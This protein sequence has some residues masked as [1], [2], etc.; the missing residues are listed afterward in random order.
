MTGLDPD[1][2]R[3]IEIAIVVTDSQL[4]TL[5]EAPVLVVHQSDNGPRCHG[6]LEQGHSRA[7]RADRQGEGLGA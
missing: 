6:R 5:S 2:D 4:N 3:I 7:H 1:R